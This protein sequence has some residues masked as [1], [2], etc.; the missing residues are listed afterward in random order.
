MVTSQKVKPRC[1]RT[2]ARVFHT[3]L[4]RCSK[5]K[6][7]HESN[8]TGSYRVIDGQRRFE[9][10]L[11]V[12]SSHCSASEK[13]S[14]ILYVSN[15]KIG[16]D[17]MGSMFECSLTVTSSQVRKC[18]SWSQFFFWLYNTTMSL[19]KWIINVKLFDI[20]F[21]L[22]RISQDVTRSPTCPNMRSQDLFFFFFFP[23]RRPRGWLEAW[24]WL[25]RTYK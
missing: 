22:S 24:A 8:A 2:G 1:C 5:A 4:Y 9:E 3:F 21:W 25:G 19:I 14:E 15:E 20:S 10:R 12:S 11:K 23:I 6:V 13:R 18:S 7:L 17:A 16:W